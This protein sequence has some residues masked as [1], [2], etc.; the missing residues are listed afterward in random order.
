MQAPFC[1]S[2]HLSR[3]A[4]A[5]PP[6]G[7]KLRPPPCR[8][9]HPERR[10]S[11]SKSS[12]SDL[13]IIPTCDRRISPPIN[14]KERTMEVEVQPIVVSDES[15]ATVCMF[16]QDTEA[17][18]LGQ[19]QWEAVHERRGRGQPRFGSWARPSGLSSAA[20][21]RREPQPSS[22]PWRGFATPPAWSRPARSG[23][24]RR[25][26]TGEA[27]R[28]R[29]LPTRQ[30]LASGKKR[31]TAESRVRASLPSPATWGCIARRCATA[32]SN[33]LGSP[34]GAWRRRACWTHIANGWPSA[35]AGQLF[36]P[37]SVAEAACEHEHQRRCLRSPI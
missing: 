9:R 15:G 35:P 28:G 30:V 24:Q 25:H 13:P 34:T 29:N 4:L 8:P 11:A 7:L 5:P 20:M 21:A 23:V 31:S 6:Q 26:P 17:P 33:R 22:V 37:D 1:A 12:V 19:Q 27:G 14:A 32:W 2:R 36:S 16:Q 10:N 18:V 3:P